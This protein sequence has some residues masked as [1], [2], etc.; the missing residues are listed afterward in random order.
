MD[1]LIDARPVAVSANGISGTGF[2]HENVA[3][4]TVH[5]DEGFLAHFHVN[6]L[7]PVKMRRMLIGGAQRVIVF[8]D[9]DP[10]GKVRGYDKGGDVD[11][12]GR[13]RRRRIL[14]S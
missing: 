11:L 10:A 9:T 8:D 5:F 1:F 3:Y 2:D 13:G 6:W 12:G 14:R 4:V 7:A